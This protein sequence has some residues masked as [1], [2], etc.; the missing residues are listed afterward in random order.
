VFTIGSA[1]QPPAPIPEPA[2]WAM[3]MLGVGLMG[4]GLRL[5]A[6][7]KAVSAAA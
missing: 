3:V 5:S 1:A 7:G 6:R 2:T 4:A